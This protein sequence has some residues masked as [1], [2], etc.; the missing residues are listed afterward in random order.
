MSGTL[1]PGLCRHDAIEAY[2]PQVPTRSEYR[3]ERITA[4]AADGHRHEAWCHVDARDLGTAVLLPRG[5]YRRHLRETGHVTSLQIR[6]HA[7]DA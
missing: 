3:R 4:H 1:L 5:D 6:P 7:V 2:H